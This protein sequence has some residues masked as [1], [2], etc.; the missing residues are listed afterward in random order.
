[1]MS[2]DVESNESVI[3]L[4]LYINSPTCYTQ[5]H[6]VEGSAWKEIN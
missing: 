5:L 1:M 6:I 2:T 4:C 3:S